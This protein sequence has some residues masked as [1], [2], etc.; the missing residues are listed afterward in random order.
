VPDLAGAAVRRLRD[1]LDRIGDALAGCRLDDLLAAQPALAAALDEVGRTGLGG[2]DA[3]AVAAEVAQARDAL[4]RCVR[5]GGSLDEA[6]RLVLAARGYT[7]GY[8]RAGREHG[9][10][11]VAATV[12]ARV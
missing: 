10:P 7:R 4:G 9:T 1:V 11:A 2:L 8:D 6:A 5:L 3:R 12:D